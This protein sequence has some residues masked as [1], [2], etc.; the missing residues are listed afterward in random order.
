MGDV[1]VKNLLKGNK[2]VSRHVGLSIKKREDLRVPERVCRVN[3]NKFLFYKI[4][5]YIADD[6]NAW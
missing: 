3:K 4:K 1:L 5:W 6:F 2:K